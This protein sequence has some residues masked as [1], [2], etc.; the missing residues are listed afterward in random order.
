MS[1]L[2]CRDL[3]KKKGDFALKGIDFSVDAGYVVGVIG[4]NG[5]GKTT[6]ARLLLGGYEPDKGDIFL[7]GIPA[8]A[9]RRGYKEH[10]AYVLNETPFPVSMTPRECEMLYSGYYCGFDRKKYRELLKSYEV[11][12]KKVLRKLSKGQQIRHQLAFALSYD[13]DVYIFDEPAANLDVKFRD[14]FYTIIRKIT[15]DGLKTVIYVS[16]L[17]D[18]LEQLADYIL[19]MSEGGQKYFGTLDGFKEGYQ[20]VEVAED[21]LGT[22]PNLAVVGIKESPMHQEVLVKAT[23][24]DLPEELKRYSRY[25]SLKEIM[26]YAEKGDEQDAAD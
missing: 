4:R 20:L 2:E 16:H 1:L 26:Y 23:R 21:E 25:A 14:E 8:S 24:K 22:F 7:R 17:V 15:E 10:L 13:A 18:E 3:T 12:E 9:D 19:W 5:A 6:L 11:P